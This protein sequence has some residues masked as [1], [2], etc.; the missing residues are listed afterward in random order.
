AAAGMLGPAEHTGLE[1]GAVDDQLTTAVKEVEQA[2]LA[3]RPVQLVLL[4]HGQPRHPPTLGGQLVT[5]A[6]QGFLLH[7]Q[8][9]A[10]SLQSLR[11]HDR[12]C[13]HSEMSTFPV[14]SR[15]SW[16]QG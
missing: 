7:E 6:G 10:G 5:G 11:R 4:R 12:G 1:E 2:H 15:W 9:L 16:D 3:L 8:E 13:V 14:L